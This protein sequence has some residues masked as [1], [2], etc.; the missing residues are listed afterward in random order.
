MPHVP[1]G[2]W[3]SDLI[4]WLL[5]TVP[6]LFDGISAVMQVLVDALTDALVSPP[7]VVWIVVFTRPVPVSCAEEPTAHDFGFLPGS[8]SRMSEGGLTV[9]MSV[10]VP[11]LP[12]VTLQSPLT[13]CF[14]A[15]LT[16]R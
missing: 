3:V 6:W 7:P 14:G 15:A 12:H 4:D 10:L 5:A 8:L 13:S 16:R 2:Q 11:C 1:L 9:N